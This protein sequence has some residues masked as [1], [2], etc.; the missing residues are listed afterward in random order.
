MVN[1]SGATFR[2]VAAICGVCSAGYRDAYRGLLPHEY[3]ERT[4]TEYDVPQRVR[5]EIAPI[6]R[7]GSAISLPR[8]A[9]GSVARPAAV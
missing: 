4:I 9:D 7:T 6:R 1:V 5:R 3:I 2:D 8:R